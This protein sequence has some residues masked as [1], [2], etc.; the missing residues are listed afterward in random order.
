MYSKRCP[1]KTKQEDIICI[2]EGLVNA[3]ECDF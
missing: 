1:V 2:Q 3:E